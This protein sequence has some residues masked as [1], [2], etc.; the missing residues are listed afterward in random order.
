MANYTKEERDKI[1][2]SIHTGPIKRYALNTCENLDKEILK[3]KSL[4]DEI[5][6][7]T[8]ELSENK[9]KRSLSVEERER[10]KEEN[11]KRRERLKKAQEE[12]EIAHK[13][14]L[15]LERA[16]D[17]YAFIYTALTGEEL[18][19]KRKTERLTEK[20]DYD[21]ESTLNLAAKL[22]KEGPDSEK[23][24][25]SDD[26]INETSLMPFV[27]MPRKRKT[28]FSVESPINQTSAT[29]TIPNDADSKNSKRFWHIVL[30]FIVIAIILITFLFTI[31]MPKKANQNTISSNTISNAQTKESSAG[32]ASEK[33]NGSTLQTN[34]DNSL[35]TSSQ[36]KRQE[37]SNQ[38]PIHISREIKV[39][40]ERVLID[41]YSDR[42]VI[43]YPS[44]VEDGDII[45]SLQSSFREFPEILDALTYD[46]SDQNQLTLS[47]QSIDS[48]N[49]LK[50][51]VSQFELTILD[52]I[53]DELN[54][55]EKKEE[56]RLSSEQAKTENKANNSKN[57]DY[58]IRRAIPILNESILINAYNGYA[59][60]SYPEDITKSDILYALG[61]LRDQNQAELN[62]V[63]YSF[64]DNQTLHLIYQTGYTRDEINQAIDRLALFLYGLVD[65]D[66]ESAENSV[67]S[68]DENEVPIS[69]SN[70]PSL[71]TSDSS[72]S[73]S[74]LTL[75]GTTPKS[76]SSGGS[77]EKAIDNFSINQ[78]PSV[79]PEESNASSGEKPKKETKSKNEIDLSVSPYSLS[80]TAFE[81][82][83]NDINLNEISKFGF[84]VNLAYRYK[85]MN[86]FKI[87]G[88]T[89]FAYYLMT[90]DG[91]DG[92]NIDKYWSVPLIF[93]LDGTVKINDKYDFYGGG[94]L[95]IS[96]SSIKSEPRIA[97]LLEFALGFNFAISGN[98]ALNIESQA[99]I[100]FPMQRF[101]GEN[102]YTLFEWQVIKVGLGIHF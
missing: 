65:E 23:K 48:E 57:D 7:L 19:P 81:R 77:D 34:P 94:G 10:I 85:L 25:N 40:D 46:N 54:Q 28:P 93:I 60:I 74:P 17:E 37:L 2:S 84:S 11:K 5:N 22:I 45:Y 68:L 24:E 102:V 21:R 72:S 9:L 3:E 59:N 41:A 95:G 75:S 30:S 80:Y 100:D 79:K 32:S 55:E 27:P 90:P 42:A 99:L 35:S 69:S 89:G 13:K 36:S 4:D 71:S 56:T 39:L 49:E 50:W 6:R 67:S 64:N 63:S 16:A 51:A 47:Y 15:A 26:E 62:N 44:F 73:P 1:L 31:K 53:D 88:E 20:K 78:G 82:K 29:A 87:G 52:K 76:S 61:K 66:I 18:N 98:I 8:K 92:L 86:N 14:A 33:R 91:Y 97:F 38:S 83:G 43:T 12:K 101:Q 58:H 96:I 70:E